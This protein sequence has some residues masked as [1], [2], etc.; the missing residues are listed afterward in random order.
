MAAKLLPNVRALMQLEG[1][2]III[3]LE[4]FE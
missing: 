3:D 2:D 4:I 1:S